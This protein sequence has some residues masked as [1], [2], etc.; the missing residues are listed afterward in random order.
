ME[1]GFWRRFLSSLLVGFAV[2]CLVGWYLAPNYSPTLRGIGSN[3][4]LAW[5]GLLV[6]VSLIWGYVFCSYSAA[7]SSS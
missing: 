1:G 4:L 5:G 3:D 6:G 7:K 2:L